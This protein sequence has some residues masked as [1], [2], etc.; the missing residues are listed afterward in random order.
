MHHADFLSLPSH[1]DAAT[2]YA[3]SVEVGQ[4]IKDSG[5]SRD[6]LWITSKV[7]SST[8]TFAAELTL[9]RL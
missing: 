7:S 3:N 6:K 4:G 1:I 5:I 8:S 9:V 2:V